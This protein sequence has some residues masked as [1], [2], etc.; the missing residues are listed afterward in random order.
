M[1]QPP[2]PGGSVSVHGC[3]RKCSRR[4]FP[5]GPR[6]Q[7]GLRPFTARPLGGGLRLH[8]HCPAAAAELGLPR[9]GP[10]AP[11]RPANGP[12]H[13][14]RP[15]SQGVVS[16]R[17]LLP[18]GQPG[19]PM[20]YELEGIGGPCG[21][22]E[23]GGQRGRQPEHAPSGGTSLRPAASLPRGVAP[24]PQFGALRAGRTVSVWAPR[25]R[26]HLGQAVLACSVST[27]CTCFPRTLYL[28]I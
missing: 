18:T 1:P 24:L 25:T 28:I 8:L 4:H 9:P 7:G 21:S 10:R 20:G 2:T 6:R 17:G 23:W 15:I 14:L 3:P 27:D 22:R 26:R 12:W 16:C 5:L 19:G 13:K 11:V